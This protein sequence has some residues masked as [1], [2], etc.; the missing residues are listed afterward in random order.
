VQLS[1]DRIGLLLVATSARTELLVGGL[2]AKLV[3]AATSA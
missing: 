1:E 2:E 3:D